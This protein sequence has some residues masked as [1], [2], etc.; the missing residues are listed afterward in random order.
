M[1][2]D[3]S[4]RRIFEILPCYVTPE[5]WGSARLTTSYVR[6]IQKKFP[7]TRIFCALYEH[8]ISNYVIKIR[9]VVFYFFRMIASILKSIN[10]FYDGGICN[11]PMNYRL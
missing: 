6:A 9:E 3:V 7:T 10:A 1:P 4:E 8:C 2:Q 5:I 11:N